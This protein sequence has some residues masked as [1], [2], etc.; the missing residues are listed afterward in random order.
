[1]FRCNI[2]GSMAE[3]GLLSEV[4][5]RPRS[6][7]DHLSEFPFRLLDTPCDEQVLIKLTAHFSE[8]QCQLATALQL[9]D[10][11]VKDIEEGWPRDLE[12]QRVQMFKRWRRNLSSQATY[13]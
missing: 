1:M 13:R 8:W 2:A 3:G 7:E 10:V 4:I 12:R 5:V 11:E 9:T 6:L